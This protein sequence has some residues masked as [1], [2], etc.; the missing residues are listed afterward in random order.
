MGA[1]GS[2]V[3]G[4]DAK[5]DLNSL[6]VSEE[7]GGRGGRIVDSVVSC[8]VVR[9]SMF[10]SAVKCKK[11]VATEMSVVRVGVGWFVFPCFDGVEKSLECGARCQRN[12]DVNGKGDL[13]CGVLCSVVVGESAVGR[14]DV[15]NAFVKP[16]CLEPLWRGKVLDFGDP[17]FTAE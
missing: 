2:F 13:P 9:E 14:S 12:C 17:D 6:E 15:C 11:V 3:D 5:V 16:D 1:F 4:K 8:V 7:D 10:S